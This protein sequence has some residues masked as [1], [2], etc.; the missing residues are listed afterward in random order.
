MDIDFGWP[1]PPHCVLASTFP[2]T[3]DGNAACIVTL[4]DGHRKAGNLI[5]FDQEAST[6]EFHPER[7]AGNLRIGFS[8]LKSIRLTSPIELKKLELPLTVETHEG[9]VIPIRQKCIIFF[10][11]GE[12]LL[13]ETV[14]Y[15]PREI[16]LFL[17]LV[18]GGNN[19]LR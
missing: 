5:G 3:N 14:G 4:N 8:S 17:F 1:L 10:K 2:A 11:D 9:A 12:R 18:S 16:G 15:V 6:L 13:S 19:V 7:A